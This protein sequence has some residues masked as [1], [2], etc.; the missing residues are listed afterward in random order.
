MSEVFQINKEQK[1]KTTEENKEVKESGDK[2][3]SYG[4]LYSESSHV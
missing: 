4:E 1:E 3:D 2:K